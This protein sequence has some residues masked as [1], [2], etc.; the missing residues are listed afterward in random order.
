MKAFSI[1]NLLGRRRPE[2]RFADHVRTKLIAAGE[3]RPIR[4]DRSA[5]ALRIGAAD[6][7][8]QQ[9]VAWLGNLFASFAQLST[10]AEQDAALVRIVASILEGNAPLP[11][12]F[13][14]AAPRLRPLVRSTADLGMWRLQSRVDGHEESVVLPHR[15]LTPQL[16]AWLAIDREETITWVMAS[17][18]AAWGVTFDD[19]FEKAL[20]NLRHLEEKPF[21]EF[22]PGLYRSDWGDRY[23]ASRL[24]LPE[25]LAGLPLKGAPVAMV[26]NRDVLLVTGADDEEGLRA[27]ARFGQGVLGQPRPLSAATLALDGGAWRAFTPD[28]SLP[29]QT[30]LAELQEVW[31]GVDYAGQKT[32]LDALHMKSGE[33]I[34]VATHASRRDREAGRFVGSF[35]VWTE[36]VDTLLPK[37]QSLA[38]VELPCRRLTEVAWDKAMPVVADLMEPTDLSPVRW[39]VR[40]FPDEVQ[41]E[42]LRAVAEQTTELPP[43]NARAAIGAQPAFDPSLYPRTYS[44]ARSWRQRGMILG[45]LV[46]VAGLVGIGYA[47]TRMAYPDQVIALAISVTAILLAAYWIA[48][49]NAW[50]VTLLDDAIEMKSLGRMRRLARDAIDGC[51]FK[52]SSLDRLAITVAAAAP[53]RGTL[54][55]PPLHGDAALVQWF[56]GLQNLDEMELERSRAAIAGDARFGAT[57]EDRLRRAARAQKIAGNLDIAATA[58][59]V[60][61]IVAPQ[62]YVAVVTMLIAI[63]AIALLLVVV[64]R[65]LYRIDA[66]RNDLHVNVGAAFFVPGFALV[67]RALIDIEMVSWVPVI[68]GG[69]GIGALLV[70]VIAVAD[71]NLRARPWMALGCALLAGTYGFGAVAEANALLDR[72]PAQAF[73]SSIVEKH[74]SRGKATR[75]V[76]KLEPWGPLTEPNE[77]S[78]PKG[79]YDGLRSGNPVCIQLRPGAL[80]MA[81]FIVVECR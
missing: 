29:G 64:S 70:G 27:M 32:L 60:W 18:L 48:D 23:D 81:W 22:E 14:D 57:P 4:Y 55:S 49:I 35:A 66:R 54:R 47:A 46:L 17:Q 7:P 6:K 75:Y 28:P 37:A 19:A 74:V 62:P 42:Q 53:A 21:V 9:T 43:D 71:R 77:V 44:V 5:F 16:V 69:L 34:F 50:R 33:D 10:A 65:G 79:L 58:A 3:R 2:D 38:F 51:R 40:R 41:L 52:G 26:P 45:G 56:S 76:L 73:H 80:A 1:S 63:P 68:A 72:S 8:D 59:V 24:L 11:L 61:G 12:S 15:H 30:G 31:A 20:S 25:L 13:V 67:A 78:V 36:G 39:R